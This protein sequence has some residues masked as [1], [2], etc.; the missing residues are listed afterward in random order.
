M[1]ASASSAE[2]SPDPR[3]KAPIHP[4]QAEPLVKMLEAVTTSNPAPLKVVFSASR[5]K[6]LDPQDEWNALLKVLQEQVRAFYGTTKLDLRAFRYDY[7]G[8]E[9]SGRVEFTYQRKL[10]DSIDVVREKDQWKMSGPTK[11]FN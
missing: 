2:P 10:R 4:P 8:N 3:L 6:D 5:L 9:K 11:G 7:I 1:A